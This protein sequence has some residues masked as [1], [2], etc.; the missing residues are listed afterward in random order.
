M[1]KIEYFGCLLIPILYIFI[2]AIFVLKTEN[3]TVF[4][5]IVAW[6]FIVFF[7]VIVVVLVLGLTCFSFENIEE[8]RDNRRADAYHVASRQVVELVHS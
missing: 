3:L 2:L 7:S 1:K 6:F 8:N 5:K 4:V